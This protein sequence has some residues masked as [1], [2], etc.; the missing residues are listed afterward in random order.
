MRPTI[1][2]LALFLCLTASATSPTLPSIDYRGP[3]CSLTTFPNGMREVPDVSLNADPNTGYVFVYQRTAQ[4]VGGTGAAA[5][6]WSGSA[7]ISNQYAAQR[8]KPRLRSPL[9]RDPP[10]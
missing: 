6:I 9:P 7:A 5:P 10:R 3:M 8:G 2:F 1:A 4:V